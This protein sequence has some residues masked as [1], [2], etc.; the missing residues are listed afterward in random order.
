MIGTSWEGITLQMFGNYLKSALGNA[1]EGIG[2][3]S[4]AKDV[5]SGVNINKVRELIRKSPSAHSLVGYGLLGGIPGAIAG[6]AISGEDDKLSGAITGGLLGTIG[7]G[8]AG[9][10]FGK[11]PTTVPSWIK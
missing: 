7:A 9:L 2:R 1:L 11:A 10:Y 4:T 8:T 5:L 6:A 3:T